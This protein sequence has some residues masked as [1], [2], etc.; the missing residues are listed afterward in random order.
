MKVILILFVLL[1]VSCSVASAFGDLSADERNMFVTVEDVREL[2]V[3]VK[4]SS[5]KAKVD[6]F[7]F[8]RSLT[9]LGGFV[10][11]EYE[12]DGKEKSSLYIYNSINKLNAMSSFTG[13]YFKKAGF[14]AAFSKKGI[15]LKELGE[16][17]Q[18]YPNFSVSIILNEG[19]PIG[20]LVSAND[21]TIDYTLILTGVFLDEPEIWAEL[22]DKKT[23]AMNA[24][25]R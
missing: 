5:E 13:K 14:A 8:A 3:A 22:I 25:M 21:G 16:L 15:V 9:W 23:T 19:K 18:R 4:G 17:K 1:P 6:K 2:G 12:Y 10:L 24:V 20:N 11:Y 7:V